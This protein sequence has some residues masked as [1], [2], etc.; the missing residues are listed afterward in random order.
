MMKIRQAEIWELYLDPVKGSEQ[1]GR[2]PAL[3]VS[4]NLM[5]THLPVVMVCPI[6]TKVKSYKGNLILEPSEENGL[7][8]RSEVLNFHLRSV[9]KERL[10]R[11]LGQIGRSEFKQV[12]EG[13]DDLLK[14]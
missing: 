8:K 3:V 14:L 2:R 11:R 7:R 12:L 1:G 9:A 6:T 5:N 4:G 10:K 13:L